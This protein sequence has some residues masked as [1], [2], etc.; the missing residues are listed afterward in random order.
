MY[1][2]FSLSLSLSPFSL[3]LS[4]SLSPPPGSPKVAIYGFCMNINRSAFVGYAVSHIHV[5][6]NM[7]M[8]GWLS[9]N[10]RARV[11]PRANL[12][13]RTRGRFETQTVC[14]HQSS[15]QRLSGSAS[16]YS[17]PRRQVA[18]TGGLLSCAGVKP[19]LCTHE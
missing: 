11:R 4:P 1:C 17:P 10:A 7:K 14:G 15:L 5:N 13:V 2:F 8:T 9:H 12:A 19:Y 18:L 16:S 3:S 6:M